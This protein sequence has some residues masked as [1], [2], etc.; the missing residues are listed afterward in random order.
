MEI[1]LKGGVAVPVGDGGAARPARLLEQGVDGER[2][3][4]DERL[5][6]GRRSVGRGR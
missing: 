1:V 2:T 5:L 4:A 6:A 3:D